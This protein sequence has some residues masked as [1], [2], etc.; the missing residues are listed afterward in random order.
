MLKGNLPLVSSPD[1]KSL[2][3]KKE[4]GVPMVYVGFAADQVASGT[5]S[6]YI[7]KLRGDATDGKYIFSCDLGKCYYSLQ[8]TSNGITTVRADESAISAGETIVVERTLPTPA[9]IAK[10]VVTEAMLK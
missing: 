4:K 8:S 2:S 6:A 10:L 3:V 7:I 9:T 5:D 1:V